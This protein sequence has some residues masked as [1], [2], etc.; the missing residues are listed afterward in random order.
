[1]L[2]MH[3]I[4]LIPSEGPY[5]KAYALN[6]LDRSLGHDALPLFE[7]VKIGEVGIC[8]VFRIDPGHDARIAVRQKLLVNLGTADDEEDFIR[9]LLRVF[10]DFPD[11]VHHLGSLDRK[12][13][14]SGQDDILTSREKPSARECIECLS[15]VDDRVTH[16]LHS[17]V[18]FLVLRETDQELSLIPDGPVL[19]YR[20]DRTNTHPLHLPSVFWFQVYHTYFPLR[21]GSYASK[22]R[23]RS[24]E[25]PLSI[26]V[27]T[28][29]DY[30]TTSI[31]IAS[32]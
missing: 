15:A 10:E 18:L 26:A 9:C 7:I 14:V 19:I 27:F 24:E 21:V 25:P 16:G 17:E 11:R 6:R 1:M 4:P 5:F 12:V 28:V 2:T 23:G 32:R 13:S 30:S 3:L 20:Y 22:K 29:S 8:F 31:W